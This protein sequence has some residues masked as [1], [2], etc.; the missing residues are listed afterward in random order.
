MIGNSSKVAAWM[1]VD[2]TSLGSHDPWK[3]QVARDVGPAQIPLQTDVRLAQT[4]AGAMLWLSTGSRPDTLLC[5]KIGQ[6]V[7]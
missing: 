4:R 1:R 3:Q 6:H 7:Q 5:F 2:E